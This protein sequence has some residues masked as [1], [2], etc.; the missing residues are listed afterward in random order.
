MYDGYGSADLQEKRK[1]PVKKL[2]AGAYLA[3]KVNSADCRYNCAL[4]A[5]LL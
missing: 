4:S 1:K 2:L 3:G 5:A